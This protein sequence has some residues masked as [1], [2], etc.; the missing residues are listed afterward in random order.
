MGHDARTCGTRRQS[1]QPGCLA[2]RT[3]GH[4]LGGS[5]PSISGVSV[6]KTLVALVGGLLAGVVLGR[7]TAASSQQ[8]AVTASAQP[9]PVPADEPD[10]DDAPDPDDPAKP[11]SPADLTRPSML[12]VLRK[13]AREFGSDQC[14]DLAAALT[15]YAVLSLFPGLVVMVSLLGVFGQGNGPPIPFCRSSTSWVRPRWWTH[16]EHPS[17]SWSRP[18]RPESHSS[19]ASPVRCGRRRDTSGHS[20]A[21]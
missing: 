5:D 20:D 18:R 2:A 17:N 7:R 12:Y 4:V 16:C 19:S 21:R 3:R 13:T 15:Y 8:P 1:R 14:T 6:R 11:D 10:P 9:A